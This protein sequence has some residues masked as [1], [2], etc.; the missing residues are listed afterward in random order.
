M[1]IALHR[2]RSSKMA[3]YIVFTRALMMGAVVEILSVV[4]TRVTVEIQS[5]H[6][7]FLS[8]Y[9]LCVGCIGVFC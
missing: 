4:Q 2:L 7:H 9:L 1:N 8:L 6:H 5:W 3:S